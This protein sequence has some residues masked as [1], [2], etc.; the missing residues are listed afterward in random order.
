MPSP[1]VLPLEALSSQAIAWMAFVTGLVALTKQG[2]DIL[3]QRKRERSEIDQALDRQPLVREQL[4]LGNTRAA[5]E[6]LSTII[7]QMA[8][9]KQRDD[10]RYHVRISELEVREREVED[11]ARRWEQR[12]NEANAEWEARYAR[13]NADW[14]TR[15]TKLDERCRKITAVLRRHNWDIDDV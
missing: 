8:E 9:A 15:Y 4:E 5:I 7:D 6:Q 12:Y 14:E 2:Y 10:R 1:N 11:D 3:R 13:N